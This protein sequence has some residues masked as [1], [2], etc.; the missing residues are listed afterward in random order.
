MKQKILVTWGMGFIGSNFLSWAVPK[1]PEIDWI[2]VDC[3]NYAADTTNLASISDAS[4]FSFY[5]WNICDEIFLEDV[6]QRGKPTDIIHFAAETHVDRSITD[7]KIFALSNVLGTQN[8][9]DMQRKYGLQRFHHVSTDEVYGD[10][11]APYS[12]K[13][14]DLLEPSSPYSSTKAGSDLLVLSYVRTFDIDATISRCT[15]NYGPHQ[16]LEK[17]IPRSIHRLKNNEPILLYGDGLNIRDWLHVQDHVEAIWQIF[18]TGKSGEIY[19]IGS[20]NERSNR[21]IAEL[22][23][24]LMGKNLDLIQYV[25]DRPGHDLRYS[26]DSTKIQRELWWKAKVDFQTGLKDLV[27]S[28]TWKE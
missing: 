23:I 4:N 14:T 13:E 8:L 9:L 24:T 11:G 17:F 10:I 26:L 19:N 1:Y 25:Q 28:L 21:E 2:C 5:K 18:T 27:I 22:L 12:S 3:L 20:G 15:N 16:D 7:P 6:F